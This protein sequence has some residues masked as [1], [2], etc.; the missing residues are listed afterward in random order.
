MK[1]FLHD[2]DFLRR[3]DLRF[4]GTG[5]SAE[6]SPGYLLALFV[7]A[8]AGSLLFAAVVTPLA[9]ALAGAV[10]AATGSS[11]AGAVREA[12]LPKIFTAL[13]WLS[14]L[15]VLPFVVRAMNV[16]SAEGLGLQADGRRVIGA[17]PWLAV[18]LAAVGAAIAGQVWAE[19]GTVRLR[20]ASL[21]ADVSTSLIIG[22]CAGLVE[23]LMFCGLVLRL[24]YGIFPAPWLAMAATAVFYALTHVKAP[25]FA[26]ESIA[27]GRTWEA[28]VQ[29]AA[30]TLL[31]PVS[32]ADP[33]RLAGL[34]AIGLACGALTLRS[35]SL[36]PGVWFYAGLVAGKQLVMKWWRADSSGSDQRW[37]LGTEQLLDGL[38]P[39]LIL[40]LLALAVIAWPRR[41]RGHPA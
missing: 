39:V 3:P 21:A 4:D 2:S 40:T 18:G 17:T 36:W 37:L 26:V 5:A 6:A 7:L 11:L 29:F 41:P 31:G 38:V 27:H 19:A 8:V 32:G 28:S 34:F 12:N 33:I 16:R 14:V 10:E 9:F 25:A 24:F 13:R 15:A 22:F 23:L 30:W 20:Q 1:T 35:G